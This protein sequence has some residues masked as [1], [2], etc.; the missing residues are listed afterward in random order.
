MPQVWRAADPEVLVPVQSPRGGNTVTTTTTEDKAVE[1]RK[2]ATETIRGERTEY[3]GK[4][5]L[6]R[7]EKTS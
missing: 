2:T 1:I 5:L 3:Q 7:I 6:E 4:D